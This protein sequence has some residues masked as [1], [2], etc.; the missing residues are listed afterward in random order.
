[1]LP[2][3]F[4][5]LSLLTG[6][7]QNSTYN[8]GCPYLYVTYVMQL[9]HAEPY[10]HVTFEIL[11]GSR[12]IITYREHIKFYCSL[13]TYKCLNIQVSEANL[14][15]NQ[16]MVILHGSVKKNRSQLEYLDQ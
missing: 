7:I 9:G 15:L 16:C 12:V 6:K 2:T 14:T 1:M 5:A 3:P 10:I 4:T 13:N 11:L 8:T